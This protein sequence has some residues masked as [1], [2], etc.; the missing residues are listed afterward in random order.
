VLGERA[1]PTVK[2]LSNSS[3]A[4]NP[5]NQVDVYKKANETA[6][7]ATLIAFYTESEQLKVERLLA[8][9]DLP[10]SEWVVVV[11]ARSD[12]K[13]SASVACPCHDAH[14]TTPSE[15]AVKPPWGRT[16]FGIALGLLIIGV[17]TAVLGYRECTDT[18]TLKADNSVVTLTACTPPTVTS[19]TVLLFLL[20][21][22]ALLW[23]DISEITV[24][25]VSLK[26][27]VA[28]ARAAAESARESVDHLRDVVQHQQ[29]QIDAVTTATA[30]STTNIHL[31]DGALLEDVRTRLRKQAE[32]V[33]EEQHRDHAPYFETSRD[34]PES[35]LKMR[36][37]SDFEVLAEMLGLWNQRGRGQVISKDHHRRSIQQF[38]LDDH[39][40]P[41]RSVRAVRN[42]VAHAQDVSRED[43]E[44]ALVILSD[45]IREA[46]QHFLR[47]DLPPES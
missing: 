12:N 10:E 2:A 3:L 34:A 14:V 45:L 37:L 19:A 30:T 42:A 22:V 6:N 7:A 8:A 46:R 21:V 31:G 23:P 28:E 39:A 43:L 18:G 25:G 36:V 24:L 1:S 41:I 16:R 47:Y 33:R 40:G 17:V 4:P 5:E 11:D 35:E 20:L 26:R 15:D 13:P 29:T 32:D 9:L 27:K 38:F 44:N